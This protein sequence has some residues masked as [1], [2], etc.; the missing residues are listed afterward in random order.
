M[1]ARFGANW[2]DDLVVQMHKPTRF[3][4]FLARK[5]GSV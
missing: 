2:A 3:M 5:D 4:G 1:Y